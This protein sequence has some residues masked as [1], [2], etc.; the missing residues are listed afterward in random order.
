MDQNR[1]T[2]IPIKDVAQILEPLIRRIVRQELAR[3]IEKHPDIF[4]LNPEMPIYQDMEHL[5][6]K[7]LENEIELFS[8]KEV[9][10]E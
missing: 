8:N 5:K 3:V 4:A 1:Q 6:K 7:Q 9:W 10:G 2:S